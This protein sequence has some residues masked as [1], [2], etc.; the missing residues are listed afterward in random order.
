MIQ[1]ISDSFG[2]LLFENGPSVPAAHLSLLVQ[3]VEIEAIG[4]GTTISP[5]KVRTIFGRAE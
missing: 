3:L 2:I 5:N 4:I 1:D